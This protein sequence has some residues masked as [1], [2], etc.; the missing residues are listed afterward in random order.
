MKWLIPIAD[1][2]PALEKD[3]KMFEPAKNADFTHKKEILEPICT[4]WLAI[5]NDVRTAI[6]N[7]DRIF[8]IPNLSF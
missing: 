3:Y 7:S 1:K 2:Y 5:A 4:G 6:A 8:F